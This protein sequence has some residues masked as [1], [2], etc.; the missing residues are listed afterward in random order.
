MATSPPPEIRRLA[1]DDAAAY[2]DI[3]LEAL[4]RHPDAFGADLDDERNMTPDDVTDR[5]ARST[6][7]GAF[8]HGDLVGVAGWYRLN[9]DKLGHRGALWG[10]Y[11]RPGARGKGLGAA[12]VRRVLDDAS[13][14]VEQLHLTV[15]TT[16]GPA[17]R[18]Y[19]R[20]G[21]AS[22]GVEPRALKFDGAY[23]DEVLM[24]RPLD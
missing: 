23:I 19:E 1:A 7:F 15:T 4:E 18:L 9:G 5:L 21:F 3:R 6:V 10:M 11:V 24:V 17:R 20:A 8:D 22:Y 14:Q 13:G 2:R 16:N 12:L